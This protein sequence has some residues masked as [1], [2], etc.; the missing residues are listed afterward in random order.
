MDV[1]PIELATGFQG[2]A[3]MFF[4]ISLIVPCFL[5]M[6]GR[7][8]LSVRIGL[9]LG[10][11]APVLGFGGIASVRSYNARTRRFGVLLVLLTA[12]LVCVRYAL[13]FLALGSFWPTVANGAGDA[14]GWSAAASS[15]PV[16]DAEAGGAAGA[17]EDAAQSPFVSALSSIG[18]LLDVVLC[19]FSVLFYCV[20]LPTLCRALVDVETR[21]APEKRKFTG[22]DDAEAGRSSRSSSQS[23]GSGAAFPDESADFASPKPGDV[24]YAGPAPPADANRWSLAEIE[25]VKIELLGLDLP[26]RRARLRELRRYY[27]PDKNAGG[28]HSVTPVFIWIQAWWEAE[29]SAGA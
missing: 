12:I 3:I 6:V 20:Y 8:T 24:G 22:P 27:H 18:S 23:Y 10:W 25:R 21:A 15:T 1:L 28:E 14:D 13:T 29:G 17:A 4:L 11:A 7:D 16:P 9:G 2:N 5:Q 26:A 19:I